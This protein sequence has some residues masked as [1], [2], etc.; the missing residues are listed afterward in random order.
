MYDV[1]MKLYFRIGEGESLDYI[2]VESK[3]L[4]PEELTPE[5][6]AERAAEALLAVAEHENCSVDEL[7][8]VD[9][10]EV[11]AFETQQKLQQMF[12]GSGL[13]DALFGSFGD[14]EDESDEE[15]S[16]EDFGDENVDEGDP[17]QS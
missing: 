9:V 5:A 4:T 12:G 10:Y 6:L 2:A 16:D 7:T 8:Q 15:E 17:F 14:D 11:K 13:L 1:V 3:P